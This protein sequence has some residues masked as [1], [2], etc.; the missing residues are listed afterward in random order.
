MC[1]T[2]EP[3]APVTQKVWPRRLLRVALALFTVE[4]GLFLAIFPWT[5]YW[6]FN[7]FQQ[8]IPGLQDL[9]DQPAFRG[10]V[11]G[12]GLVNIYLAGLQVVNAFRRR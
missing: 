8:A 7:Y 11:T 1:V 3:A 5:D 6:N 12:L 4:I 10:A 9:W 2:P